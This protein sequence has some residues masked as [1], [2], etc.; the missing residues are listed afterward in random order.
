MKVKPL[1]P[2]AHEVSLKAIK[3]DPSFADFALVRQ[4][5]LSVVPVGDAHWR[6]LCKMAGIAI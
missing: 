5:R 1:H 6:A 2:A 4:S 3:A